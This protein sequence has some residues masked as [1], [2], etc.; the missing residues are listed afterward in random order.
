MERFQLALGSPGTS[1]DLGSELYS[2]LERVKY[3]AKRMSD[4][5]AEQ[6]SQNHDL[7]RDASPS[8]EEVGAKSE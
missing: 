7:E 3:Q 1:N 5:F 2:D 8:L 4:D 6:Q